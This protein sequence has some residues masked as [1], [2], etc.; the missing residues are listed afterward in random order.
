MQSYFNTQQFSIMMMETVVNL[1]SESSLYC[2]Y[3]GVCFPLSIS[4][5]YYNL[6]ISSVLLEVISE[7]SSL[8]C[9]LWLRIGWPKIKFYNRLNSQARVCKMFYYTLQAKVK[10]FKG[11]T[12][13]TGFEGFKFLLNKVDKSKDWEPSLLWLHCAHTWNIKYLF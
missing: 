9:Q 13:N 12:T 2:I 11:G 4:L 3:F 6:C 10:L 7:Q 1:I 5:L 8:H